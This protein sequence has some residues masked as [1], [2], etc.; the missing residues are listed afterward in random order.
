MKWLKRFNESLIS[1]KFYYHVTPNINLGS[2]KAKG[3]NGPVYL[4]DNFDKAVLWRDIKMD[5]MLEN[6]EEVIK[7]WIVLKLKNLDES[8]MNHKDYYEKDFLSILISGD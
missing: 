4:T 6:G 3:L 7:D 5:E 2:I 1:N 8:K